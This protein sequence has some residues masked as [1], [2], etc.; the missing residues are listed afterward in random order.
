MTRE[1]SLADINQAQQPYQGGWLSHALQIARFGIVGVG[2]TLVHL[3]VAWVLLHTTGLPLLA[4]TCLSNER[5]TGQ[6]RRLQ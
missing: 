2:A 1:P 4:I 6:V 5:L 3:C